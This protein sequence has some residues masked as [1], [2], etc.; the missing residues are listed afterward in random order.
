MYLH[1]SGPVGGQSVI[2]LHGTGSNG[3]M[4]KSHM[5]ILN[6]YHCLAPDYPGFGRS[7]NQ[8][9]TT[10]DEIATELIDVVRKHA[11]ERKV[12]I[13]GISLGGAIAIRLLGMIPGLLESVIVDG[14]SV[15]PIRGQFMMRIGLRLLQPF[16][17]TDFVI[18]AISR[19]L[20]RI[21]EEDYEEFRKGMLLVSPASFTRSIIQANHIRQ[22]HGLKHVPCR[23]LFVAG[24]KESKT[25]LRSNA[26][27][28]E[29][30]PKAINRVVLGVRHGWMSEALDL[31]IRM[32]EEWLG[33][34]PLPGELIRAGF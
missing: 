25:T 31:H 34:R 26:M 4:W 23:V 30:M 1:E 20:V 17:H 7:G 16:I 28:A 5:A 13:V 18:K 21:P 9:W 22:P 3:T 2:L 8:E 24:E 15:L 32:V 27:L 29:L 33:D 14:A 12:H 19:T 6:N 10:I 11:Q